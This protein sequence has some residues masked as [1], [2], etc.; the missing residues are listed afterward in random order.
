MATTIDARVDDTFILLPILERTGRGLSKSALVRRL[1]LLLPLAPLAACATPSPYVTTVGILKPGATLAVRVDSATVN[2]YQPEVG[3]RRDLFTIS[4]T[5][6]AKST[7]PPAPRMRAVPLGLTV[8]AKGTL[9]SLLVRVPD[10]V[11]LV[12]ES[13]RGDV[14]VTDIT[15]NA[16]V[17]AQKGNVDVKLPGYAQA[18]VGTGN[19]SVTM[20][21]TNWPGTLRFSTRRGDIELWISAKAS[22][23]V[24]L[25][26][27]NGVL[28]TDFGLRGTSNGEA[29]TIDG[30]V[31]GSSAQRIDVE[32]SAGAIRLL[33]LQ[34]QP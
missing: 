5:A 32:A 22:F 1:L 3:Q 20:G 17:L 12:V 28:F 18:A 13:N 10:G 33:R 23:G 7:P 34:P 26:T 27:G 29:E 31:N 6:P 2:A 19:L 21:A 16:R 8:R 15:G 11:D 25:H 14:N 4:A 30:S 24:H 9:D